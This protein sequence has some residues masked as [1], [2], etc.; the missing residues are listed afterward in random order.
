MKPFKAFTLVITI[1][2]F[3]VFSYAQSVDNTMDW[4]E[5]TQPKPYTKPI[6]NEIVGTPYVD[7][8]FQRGNVF[9]DG[10]LLASNVQLRYNALRDEIE[11][12]KENSSD[13]SVNVLVRDKDI[14][15][16]IL[17]DTYVYLE[18]TSEDVPTGYY[19]V[20]HEDVNASLYKKQKKEFIEGKKSINTMTRDIAPAFK[21]AEELYIVL[22]GGQLEPVP[23]SRGKRLKLLD[24][25]KKEVK[26]FVRDNDLNINKDYN[27]LKLIK[28][29]NRL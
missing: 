22:A 10:A 13:N 4:K 5:F 23:N 26:Q 19:L 12:Q 11:I 17:N 7:A 28:Y 21:D 15:V 9:N 27:Y 2:L 14:Y 29:Y 20:M 25:H 24:A 6:S 16:K 1:T 18:G 3:S 8:T